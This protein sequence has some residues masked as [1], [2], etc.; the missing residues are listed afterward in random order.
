MQE[1]PPKFHDCVPEHFVEVTE[2]FLA[3]F[4]PLIWWLYLPIYLLNYYLTFW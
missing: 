4:S 1:I 3:S 2:G